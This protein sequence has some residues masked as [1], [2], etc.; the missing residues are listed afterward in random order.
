METKNKTFGEDGTDD[1]VEGLI[2]FVRG[3]DYFDYNG[4]CNID[5][6]RPHMLG[7][8]YNSQLVEVGIPSAN[9]SF[10]NINQEAYWRVKNNYSAFITQEYDRKNIIYA[11]AN[12]GMLHAFNAKTGEEEW[13]F[14]PPFVAGRLPIIVNPNLDG[15]VNFVKKQRLRLSGTTLQ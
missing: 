8:I 9:Q 7:D 3:K 10:T 6:D 12:D 1:D 2:N 15:K 11:G 4:D 14:V 13:G 5:D